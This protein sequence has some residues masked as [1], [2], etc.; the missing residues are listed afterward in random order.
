V[1]N[2]EAERKLMAILGKTEGQLLIAALREKGERRNLDGM[3]FVYFNP[4]CTLDEY[5]TYIWGDSK[6]TDTCKLYEEALQES[7]VDWVHYK[8]DLVRKAI[9][10]FGL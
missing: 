2:S 5:V 1:A 8:Y 10:Y 4:S 9:R 6:S 3:V 7:G